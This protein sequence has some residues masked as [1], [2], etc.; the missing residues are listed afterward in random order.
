MGYKGSEAVLI[1]WIV[2]LPDSL[3]TRNWY[4]KACISPM[5]ILLTEITPFAHHVVNY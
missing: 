3:A 1:D 4:K 2:F 5:S